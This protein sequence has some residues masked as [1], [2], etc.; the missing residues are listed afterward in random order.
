MIQVPSRGATFQNFLQT[1]T[2]QPQPDALIRT[3]DI[4]KT[5]R[6]RREAAAIAL[7]VDP[8]GEARG[9]E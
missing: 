5:V 6:R 1:F 2:G 7:Q 8:Q 4:D 3:A 9:A